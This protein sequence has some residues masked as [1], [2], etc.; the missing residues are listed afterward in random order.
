MWQHNYSILG[1]NIFLTAIVAAI[2]IFFLFWA[3]AVKKMKGYLAGVYTL[4]IAII[5]AVVIYK[6][7]VGAAISAAFLGIFNGLF[8]LVWIVITAV[9]LFN[10]VV[11][12]GKFEVIKSSISSIS[13]DRRIQA[14]LIAFCF[15]S[16]LEAV[17][18]QGAPVAVA[19]AMLIGLGFKPMT[20]ALVCLIA[21][22]PPVPFGP[23]GVPTITTAK[24]AELSVTPIAQAIGREMIIF[25]FIIPIFMLVVMVGWKKTKEVLPAAL[26]AGGSFGLVFYLVSNFVGP[27]LTSIIASISSLLI[28]VAFLK[29]WKPKTI[30]RFDS[31]KETSKTKEVKFNG[32]EILKA[33][34]PFLIVMIVMGIW[35]SPQFKAFVAEDLKWFINIKEWPG[36]HGIVYRVAPIVK[37]PAIYAASY[38]LDY[39]GAAGTAL[40]ISSCISL[41]ILKIKLSKAIEVFGKTCKQLVYSAI[42]IASVIGF[43]YV[44]NYSGMS[45]SY[46]LAFAATGGLFVIFSPIIGGLGTFL[47]GSVTSSGSLFGKLQVVSAQQAGLNPILTVSA[48]LLGAC[49]GK[50]ISPPSIAVAAASAGLVGKESEI[51][52]STFKYFLMLMG[53]VVVAVLI[54]AYVIPG[55]IPTI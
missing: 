55:I 4:V 13:P 39:F 29:F 19:A 26:V 47:T 16:F 25:S 6:M 54:F 14:L 37:E 7:P 30:W 5:V 42:T 3:L 9:F 24:V 45:Y 52:R 32:K 46:G 40:L 53:F 8:P 43:A 18:G 17:A 35:G 49:M 11:E 48:N 28:L 36:L 15:S 2:P 41:F 1:D 38:K 51:F 31:D 22:V 44:A 21:N 34:S 23:V 20:A 10:L 27:E 33:W 12:S 50:L